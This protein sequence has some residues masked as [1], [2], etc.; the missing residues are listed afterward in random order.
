MCLEDYA[1]GFSTFSGEVVKSVDVASGILV[2]A[3]PNRSFLIITHPIGNPVFVSTIN[4]ATIASGLHLGTGDQPLL[5]DVK[6]YG[7]LC[8]K[9]W[10]A[11]ASGGAAALSVFEGE[12]DLQRAKEFMAKLKAG[13]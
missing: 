5:I 1:I 9:A 11:I 2:A 13:Y 8:T 3:N 4:P 10:Y 12:F 6:T 7:N